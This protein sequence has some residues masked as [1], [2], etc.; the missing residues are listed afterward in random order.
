MSRYKDYLMEWENRIHEIEGY[1][2]KISESESIDETVDFVVNKLKPKYDFEKVNI[3]NIVSEHW[4]I[5]WE[6]HNVRGC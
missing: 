6:K 1:E 4:N 3:R 5:Y 2:N